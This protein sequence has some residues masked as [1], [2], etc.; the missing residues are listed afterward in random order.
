M[1]IKK[2]FLFRAACAFAL[3]LLVGVPIL[4]PCSG[5]LGHMGEA[6]LL[7]PLGALVAAIGLAIIVARA[8]A[9]QRRTV[10]RLSLASYAVYAVVTLLISVGGAYAMNACVPDPTRADEWLMIWALFLFPFSVPIA[11]FTV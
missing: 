8:P 9:G 6:L 1:N 3:V 2:W 5:Y 11:Y 4:V 7:I 10:L